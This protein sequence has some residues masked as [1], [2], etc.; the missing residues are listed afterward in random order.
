MIAVLHPPDEAERVGRVRAIGRHTATDGSLDSL[1][2]RALMMLP[3]ADSAAICLI[4]G[5]MQWAIASAGR[6]WSEAPRTNS[7]CSHVILHQGVMVVQDAARD[8]RFAD[9]PMVV[10]YPG[11]RFYAGAPL[12][13]QV[14]TLCVIGLHPRLVTET[15]ISTLTMLARAAGHRLALHRAVRG[16]WRDMSGL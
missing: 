16:L 12:E 10:G 13:G 2:Q 5:A 8:I 7:F 4:G 3:G 15:E 6:Q 9:H 14:G 11:I 1:V